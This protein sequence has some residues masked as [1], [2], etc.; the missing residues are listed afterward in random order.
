MITFRQRNKI[1]VFEFSG[2]LTACDVRAGL[3]QCEEKYE[4]EGGLLGVIVDLT[5]VTK[6]VFRAH[7]VAH[8]N[9]H[10]MANYTP[11]AIVGS[12]DAGT[13]LVLGT[14]IATRK[15]NDIALFATFAEALDWLKMW[16]KVPLF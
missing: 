13:R 2:Q 3:L 1:L 10:Q 7:L 9:I 16:Y 11:V 12:L 14:Y 6:F 4:Q 15:E 5:N 8:T